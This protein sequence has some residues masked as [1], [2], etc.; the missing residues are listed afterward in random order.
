[1]THV[2]ATEFGAKGIRV[3]LV[4][5][6][7]IETPMMAAAPAIMTKVQLELTPLER[8][9]KPEDVA[10]AVAFLISDISGYISGAELPV[11]GAFTSSSGVKY[12]SDTI[13]SFVKQQN[14]K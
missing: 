1:M 14:N 12:M 2:A 4:N 11:D 13:R 8:I 5:P 6:G 3:N 9:G 7:Y 10:A